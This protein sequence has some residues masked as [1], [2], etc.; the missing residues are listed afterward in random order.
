LKDKWRKAEKQAEDIVKDGEEKW[1]KLWQNGGTSELTELHQLFLDIAG[2]MKSTRDR[3][4]QERQ[5]AE[6]EDRDARERLEGAMETVAIRCGF[7]DSSDANTKLAA[8]KEAE[9]AGGSNEAE[10]GGGSYGRGT[11]KGQQNRATGAAALHLNGKGPSPG[12]TPS[13]GG[14]TKSPSPGKE[15][16]PAGSGKGR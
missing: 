7:K 16:S 11:A 13:P 10:A 9:A 15:Q 1:I 5:E 3:K 14:Q 2:T 12:S 4:E 6:E 8:E